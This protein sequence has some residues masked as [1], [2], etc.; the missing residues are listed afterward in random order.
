MPA[1]NP[2]D[3]HHFLPVFY[4]KRWQGPDGLIEFA[5]RG[6]GKIEGRPCSPKSTGYRPG[7][8]SNQY[9]PDPMKAAALETEFMQVL[10]RQ[11]AAALE[12]MEKDSDVPWTPKQRSDWSRFLLSLLQ[13]V[14]EEV[15]VFKQTFSEFF[16]KVNSHDEER[17]KAL[18]WDGLPETLAEFLDKRKE[19]AEAG[20]LRTLQ[21]L[22]GHS[23]TAARC[24]RLWACRR[25]STRSASSS[26]SS[27]A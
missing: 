19:F 11:A 16:Q 5:R 27:S 7:L 10:D 25:N 26:T 1:N 6:N 3:D 20:S 13:R 12:R 9:H 15:K 22:I 14:P 23:G 21:S 2:S 8:Y 17:Y 24:C 4:L 18:R